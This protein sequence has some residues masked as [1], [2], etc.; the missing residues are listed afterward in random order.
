MSASAASEAVPPPVPSAAWTRW[1]RRAAIGGAAAAGVAV[2]GMLAAGWYFSGELDRQ[3]L[4]IDHSPDAFDLVAAP[5]ADGVVRL[6]EGPAGGGWTR[7]G[8]YGLAGSDGVP[9]I[10]ML[11]VGYGQR[12]VPRNVKIARGGSTNRQSG[13]W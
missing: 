5:V 3:G 13:D 10:P 6:S 8:T 2:I 9:A 1:A 7:D 4:R 11:H 12:N